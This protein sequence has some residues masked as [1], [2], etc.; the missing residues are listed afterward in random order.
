MPKPA[1]KKEKDPEGRMPLADH[2]REL[3]N[4][5]AK[6]L[7]AIV[8]VTVVAAFFYNDIIN[9]LTDPILKSV[10]CR[11]SFEELAKS[12]EDVK[13][14]RITMNGLLAP[15]TL[16]LQVSLTAGVVFASPV[17]LYQMWAFVAPG[18]HQHE[19][20]YAYAFVLTGAPLFLGGA[21]FAYKVLPTTAKVL[22]EFTPNGDVNNFLPLDDLLQLVTRMVVVF[23]LSFELPLLLIMLNLTGVLT[24]RRMLGWWRAM[25]MGITVFAA[26]ATP[27]TDPVSMLALAGPIWVLYFGAV[28]FSLLNDRRRR[29]RELSGPADDE[30]S[31]LDLTPE[32]IDEVE[33][34]TAGRVLPEQT[35]TERVN[36]YDDVT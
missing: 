16:A 33:P 4:R 19:R 32:S 9:F 17:W 31:E 8:V 18:L 21:F 10:G 36:G 35:S 22:L 30:A 2:L 26:V 23:G 5:L 20:K 28:A 14:A 11:Q 1:R 6:A 13:C 24:G 15:F 25:I 34:V 12:S 7:L 29:R 27:S 3:R